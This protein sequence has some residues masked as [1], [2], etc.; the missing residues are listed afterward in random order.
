MTPVAK[1]RL[2]VPRPPATPSS[3]VPGAVGAAGRGEASAG[4]QPPL[5]GS[6]APPCQPRS[7]LGTLARGPSPLPCPH[8]R[9]RAACTPRNPWSLARGPERQLGSPA[10]P[11]PAPPPPRRRRGAHHRPRCP[12]VC[13]KPPC[14]GPQGTG[15]PVCRRTLAGGGCEGGGGGRAPPRPAA[16]GRS[17]NHAC[18]SPCTSMARPKSA[19]FTAA[20]LHLLARSRFSGCGTHGFRRDP[21][22]EEERG[23]G[24]RR[25]SPGTAGTGG[26]GP[27]P[28]PHR[29]SRCRV[30][31]GPQGRTQV[32]APRES[33]R[34][35]VPRG[36]P[37]ARLPA[38]R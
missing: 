21:Q 29:G 4:R 28:R 11:D 36:L 1:G 37:P 33:W 23:R 18:W 26:P 30:G 5:R 31:L 6:W 15:S 9:H 34:G 25:A 2:S 27:G 24:C 22:G 12:P 35:T 3:P 13:R 32:S 7:F 8:P 16:R 38:G 10:P 17:P 20:P 19:S 14:A